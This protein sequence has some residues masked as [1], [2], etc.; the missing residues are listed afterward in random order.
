MHKCLREG[1]QTRQLPQ[2]LDFQ[3]KKLK[4]KEQAYV[5]NIN[6]EFINIFKHYYSSD[7]Q[8]PTTPEEGAK[9]SLSSLNVIFFK[10]E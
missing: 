7:L 3:K 9:T 10:F 1:V 2:P 4:L 5:R 8:S 6:A